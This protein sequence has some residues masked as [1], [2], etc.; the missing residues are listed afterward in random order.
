MIVNS[1]ATLKKIVNGWQEKVEEYKRTL[2]E[3]KNLIKKKEEHNLV[4]E[5]QTKTS[6]KSEVNKEKDFLKSQ[7]ALKNKE[8]E[9]T[10]IAVQM[11][12]SELCD[13]KASKG[14]LIKELSD[15]IAFLE[16]Q[17]KAKEDNE[18]NNQWHTEA[19]RLKSELDKAK[20]R[21]KFLEEEKGRVDLE[22]SML[23]GHL[24]ANQRIRLL[25]KIK[26][27]NNNF[28]A[29][30]YKLREEGKLMR[31]KLIRTEKDFQYLQSKC[32]LSSGES[33]PS[34]YEERIKELEERVQ[35]EVEVLMELSK[36]PEASSLHLEDSSKDPIDIIIQAIKYLTKVVFSS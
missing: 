21:M 22:I 4:L 18:E 34:K 1:Q 7:L 24:N 30:N 13:V 26:E 23:N 9:E 16:S 3:L 6:I 27:E 29:E 28:R 11:L 32:K 12:D 33:L 19:I 31:E 17:L 36:L 2:E 15:R 25:Q 35:R 14:S 8:L 10:R 20:G 5:E